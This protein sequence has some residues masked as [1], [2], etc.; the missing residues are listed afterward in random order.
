VERK[1]RDNIN[2]RIQ[3]LDELIPDPE[4]MKKGA[5]KF[6]GY[7]LRKALDYVRACKL[8]IYVAD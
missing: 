3:E 7:I 5:K 8:I 6:K 1:R 4:P 2:E